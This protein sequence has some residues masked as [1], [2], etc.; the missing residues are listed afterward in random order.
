MDKG[1]WKPHDKSMTLGWLATFLGIMWSWGVIAIEQ[2][3]FDPTKRE[4]AGQAPALAKTTAELL[5]LFDQNVAAYRKALAASGD[6]QLM[7]SWALLFGGQVYFRQP[8]WLVLRT[9]IMN[10]AVH[11]RAQL[12]TY[13]R[14]NGIA[15]PAIY[16]DSAD[17]KGGLFR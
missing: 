1:D 2:E 16:N 9:F 14:L 3:S 5:A 11:H 10:H 7:K 6:A 8:R 13:L 15:V 12:G 4:G 17:E